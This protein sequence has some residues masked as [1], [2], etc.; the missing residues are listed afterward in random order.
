MPTLIKHLVTTSLVVFS[1]FA[2][3]ACVVRGPQPVAYSPGYYQTR[4]V[5]TVVYTQPQQTVVYAQPQQT[6]VYAAPQPQYVQPVPTA[7]Y[8]APQPQY[9]RPAPG[10]GVSVGGGVGVGGVGV[11]AGGGVRVG[12]P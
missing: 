6:V 1:A 11:S 8:A 4:P 9:V 2:L 5:Q 7:V 3:D 12:L 10:V